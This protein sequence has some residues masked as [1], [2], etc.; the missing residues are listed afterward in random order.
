[1]ER[2]VERGGKEKGQKKRT[3]ERVRKKGPEKKIATAKDVSFS[4]SFLP[5]CMAQA[6]VFFIGF[7]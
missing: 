7:L 3:R 4:F 1:M 6:F 5:T 2:E